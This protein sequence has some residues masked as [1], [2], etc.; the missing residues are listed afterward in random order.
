MKASYAFTPGA[1][2]SKWDA[3]LGEYRSLTVEEQE[4]HDN[5]KTTLTMDRRALILENFK[6]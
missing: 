1:A 3:Q 4:R 6:L 5:K 2:E